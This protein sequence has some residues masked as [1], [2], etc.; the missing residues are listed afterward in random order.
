[1]IIKNAYFH[2]NTSIKMSVNE[3]LIAELRQ[4]AANTRK[5]L[6]RVPLDDPDW[7]PHRK[8]MPIGRLA[9]HVAE[10]PGWT[11]MTLL[12][13]E[14]DLTK[15]NERRK[16]KTTEE[17]LAI[18]DEHVA[19][20]VSVLEHFDEARYNENWTMRTGSMVHFTLPKYAVLRTFA[21]SHLFHHRAQL[22][23]YLRLLDIPIPGMYGPTADEIEERM[24]AAKAKALV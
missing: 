22:G 8:S 19:Q 16:V 1:M 17:L 4:E 3:K 24:A 9:A 13:D 7:R 2:G 12:T 11:A 5:L 20:A 10:I 23:L 18:H 14:L 21:F 6:E 15:M